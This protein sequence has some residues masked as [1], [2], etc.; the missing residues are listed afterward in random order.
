MSKGN[1]LIEDNKYKILRKIKIKFN[2]PEFEKLV[3]QRTNINPES[4][5]KYPLIVKNKE[6]QNRENEILK[7]QE[8]LKY[9][10]KNLSKI[11]IDLMNH[12]IYVE[13]KF[14]KSNENRNYKFPRYISDNTGIKSKEEQLNGNI[15]I[16]IIRYLYSLI[17]I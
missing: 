17:Y 15:C 7:L 6:N 12:R 10:L 16:K 8:A 1:D 13:K 14:N 5:I 2:K 11:E 3:S 9:P 4:D